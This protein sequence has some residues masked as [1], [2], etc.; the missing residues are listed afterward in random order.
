MAPNSASSSTHFETQ[1]SFC[2]TRGILRRTWMEVS[3]TYCPYSSINTVMASFSSLIFWYIDLLPYCAMFLRQ[4][5]WMGVSVLYEAGEYSKE[6]VIN[7]NSIYSAWCVCVRW[8]C[9]DDIYLI[10]PGDLKL[11]HHERAWSEH[12]Y[13][14]ANQPSFVLPWCI[15]VLRIYAGIVTTATFKLTNLC[16]YLYFII[17]WTLSSIVHLRY[18]A[19][20]KWKFKTLII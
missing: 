18:T 14:C 16:T 5:I 1:D 15:G 10:L 7:K 13:H 11:R 3:V 9:I 20:S 17:T 6:R 19:T 8:F 12:F 2:I 4:T